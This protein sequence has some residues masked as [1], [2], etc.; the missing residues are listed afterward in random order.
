MG[1]ATAAPLGMRRV[2]D[3]DPD[4]GAQLSRADHAHA[5]K[6]A[7]APCTRLQPGTWHPVT[8]DRHA[9]GLLVLDGA[10]ARYASIDGHHGVELVGPGDLLRPWDT[11]DTG[12]AAFVEAWEILATTRIALLDAN[13]S[14]AVSR[15]PGIVAELVARSVLRSG[16]LVR[17]RAVARLPHLESRVL[18][19]LWDIADRWGHVERDGVSLSLPITQRLLA[20]LVSAS[21]QRVNAALAELVQTGRVER[22]DDRLLLRHGSLDMARAAIPTGR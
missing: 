18:L 5:R 15:W 20:D 7:V 4:L 17:H 1:T 12:T 2:L 9:L 8:Q 16:A 6:A 11:D 13:F 10:L 22:R 14:S 21:R 19:V 3:D